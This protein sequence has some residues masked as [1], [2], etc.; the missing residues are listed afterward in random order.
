MKR[1]LIALLVLALGIVGS[2]Q[3]EI[4]TEVLESGFGPTAKVGQTVVVSYRLVT[5]K[6]MLIEI[7]S[8]REPL[9][10]ELGSDS[11]LKGFNQGVEGMQLQEKREIRVPPSLGYGSV[12]VGYIPADSTLVFTVRLLQI[13][14]TPSPA[15][16]EHNHDEATGHDEHGH[17]H[18]HDPAEQEEVSHDHDGDGV[19]DHSADEHELANQFQDPEFLKSRHAQD[20]TKPAMF[21]Y[22]IRDFYTKPWRYE[23]GHRKVWNYNLKTFLVLIVAVA[24]FGLGVRK[25]WL[26]K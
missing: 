18:E 22:V 17:E 9:T 7:R 8:E 21:E 23:D 13:K 5:D 16:A 1:L 6:D 11:M 3:D 24:L 25:G 19:P 10:F 20:I 26:V 15:E 4:S 2:A 12:D 14:D